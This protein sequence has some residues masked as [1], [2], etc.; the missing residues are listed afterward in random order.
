SLFEKSVA[1]QMPE[2]ADLHV[3]EKIEP[4]RVERV[5]PMGNASRRSQNPVLAAH[6]T[7]AARRS[8]SA[9]DFRWSLNQRISPSFTTV[10]MVS[11]ARNRY[12]YQF[13]VTVS[14]SSQISPLRSAR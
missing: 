1:A 13:T 3:D 11:W 4:G 9:R 2:V 5:F 14:S 7:R 8:G 12:L 10:R 6:P